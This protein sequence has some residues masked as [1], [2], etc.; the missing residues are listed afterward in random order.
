[1]HESSIAS[2][3]SA[4]ALPRASPASLPS[5]SLCRAPQDARCGAAGRGPS[6]EALHLGHLI[7]F[8]MTKWLQDA[9]R[10]PLVIQ[11][12]DDEKCLWKGLDTDKARRLAFENCK[13]II[14]CGFDV[15]R[16][17]VFSDFEYVGGAFYR[18]VNRI[19]QKVRIRGRDRGALSLS[20][21]RIECGIV[22]C[23]ARII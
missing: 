12:T 9:F 11:L 10:C 17:F 20:S 1:V 13:D 8:M 6:S 7:P 3:P 18:M 21:T 15:S 19:Q 16:T 2:L 4:R 23:T 22:P 14:A 5:A